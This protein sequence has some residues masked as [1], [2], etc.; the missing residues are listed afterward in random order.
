MYQH[1]PLC[2]KRQISYTYL[3]NCFQALP[4]GPYAELNKLAIEG[5]LG[6]CW[7]SNGQCFVI[8]LD[9]MGS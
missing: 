3:Q 4:N 9:I 2:H 1:S 5:V 7:G 6:L 8:F